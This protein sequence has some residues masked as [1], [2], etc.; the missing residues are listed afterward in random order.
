MPFLLVTGP[1]ACGKS[2]IVERIQEYFI[3]QGKPTKVVRDDDCPNFSR[4]DYGYELFLI[5]KLCTT[6]FAVL[7]CHADESTCKWLNGQKNE[8]ARYKESVITELFMR[9]EK[10]DPRNRWDSPLYEIM[11]GSSESYPEEA[12]DDM[13]IDLEHPSP[14]FADIPLSE[15]FSWMCEGK[16]LIPNQSTQVA[17][18]APINFFHELAHVTQEVISEIIRG[19][20]TAVVG[21]H[22]VITA[23]NPTPDTVVVGRCRT[24]AELTRLRRQFINTTK[25]NPV[26]SKTKIASLFIHFLNTNL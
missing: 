7:Y 6:T 20:R 10:P 23:F 16:P 15:L 26:D 2:T 3:G 24:L 14:R 5:G 25:G 21:Q 17:P 11:I 22:I 19:Q 8:N 1:P 4:D 12:P 9:Y 13:G 18:I